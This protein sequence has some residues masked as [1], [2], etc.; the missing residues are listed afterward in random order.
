MAGSGHAHRGVHPQPGL[1]G[2]PV[3]RGAPGADHRIGQF[4]RGHDRRPHRPAHPGGRMKAVGAGGEVALKGVGDFS[5][6][7]TA[8]RA[9]LRRLWRLKWGMA[10]A[11]LLL[12]IVASAVLAPWLAPYD[13]LAV[14]IQHRLAPPV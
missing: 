5:P 13:P 4:P 9:S 2:G 6:E 10:A 11:A 12:L 3:R 8:A 7:S 1:P 14:D